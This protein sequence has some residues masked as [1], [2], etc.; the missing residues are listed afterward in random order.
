M[1][2]PKTIITLSK[3][4]FCNIDNRNDKN[5]I[6]VETNDDNKTT[7]YSNDNK[8]TKCS[9]D[10]NKSIKYSN[11]NNKVERQMIPKAITILSRNSQIMMTETIK[12]PS[13]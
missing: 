2:K 8:S 6:K 9:N 4:E 3:S 5:T 13:E 11:K 10:D 7:K 1:V 12:M